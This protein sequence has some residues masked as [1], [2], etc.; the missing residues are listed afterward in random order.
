MIQANATVA[1]GTEL[2]SEARS[3]VRCDYIERQHADLFASI[4]RAP[5]GERIEPGDGGAFC[6]SL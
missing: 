4:G 1:A 5:T 6:D 3:R 2:L